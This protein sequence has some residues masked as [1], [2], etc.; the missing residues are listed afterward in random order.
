MFLLLL[1]YFATY[2]SDAYRIGVFHEA[3]LERKLVL[4][5][6]FIRITLEYLYCTNIYLFELL[7]S[8]I[9]MFKDSTDLYLFRPIA[10]SI[11][12]F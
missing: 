10:T 4:I 8:R 7:L 2:F 12:I 9:V 6:V 3:G 5:Y 1:V 11:D